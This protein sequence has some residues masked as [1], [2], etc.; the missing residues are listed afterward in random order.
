MDIRDIYK[1]FL[2]LEAQYEAKKPDAN[3]N[4]I[5]DYAEDGKG[6]NDLKKKDEVVDEW[7]NS[8]D[9]EYKDDDFMT[10][11]MGTDMHRKKHRKAIRA[12]DP[13][14]EAQEELESIKL[15]IREALDEKLGKSKCNECGKPKLTPT[16]LEEIANLAEGEQHGNSQIY[17]KCWKG[18]R[19]VAGKARGEPGSCKCD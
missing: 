16:E 15:K 2:A 10:K 12:K 18:C 1:N 13:A 7:D 11:D 14:M 3:K 19:K 4:G 8:P 6:K 9:A 5:P 17:D